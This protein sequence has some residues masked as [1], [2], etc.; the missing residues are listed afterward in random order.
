[1]FKGIKEDAFV[2][3]KKKK[4]EADCN[5]VINNEIHVKEKA[6]QAK[7][8]TIVNWFD[9]GIIVNFYRFPRVKRR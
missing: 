1:M 6:R 5:T 4:V 3:E 9:R 2:P 8:N 7:L